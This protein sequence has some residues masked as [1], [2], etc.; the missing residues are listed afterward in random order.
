MVQDRQKPDRAGR[1]GGDPRKAAVPMPGTPRGFCP[2][3]SDGAWVSWSPSSALPPGPGQ[4]PGGLRR[5]CQVG[6]DLS[7]QPPPPGGAWTSLGHPPTAPAQPPPACPA[8]GPGGLPRLLA[9]QGPRRLRRSCLG[10]R[11]ELEPLQEL[12]Q[13]TGDGQ[14]GPWGRLPHFV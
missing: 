7:T 4:E 2:N 13:G 12:E 9:D 14:D 5:L 6:P 8:S 1:P 3:T 11:L 10:V